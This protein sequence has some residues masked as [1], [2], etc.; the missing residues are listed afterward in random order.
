MIVFITAHDEPTSENLQVAGHLLRVATN[1][2]LGEDAV[3]ANIVAALTAEPNQPLLAFSHGHPESIRG[4]DDQ[5]AL[6]IADTHLLCDRESF[7]F[8]CHT[9]GLLGPNVSARGGTWFGYV[10]AVN[11][12]PADQDAI[13]HFSAIADFVA[14]RFPGCNTALGAQAF[15]NDIAALTDQK[16][17][18]ILATDTYTFEMLHALRDIS[19]RLRIWLP[20][21][22][23]AIM[24]PEGFGDP[25]F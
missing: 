5:P 9:A 15:I 18:A 1:G 17:E 24:H 14:R 23:A 3:R 6:M 11:C 22:A 7:A 2:L 4:N 20:G 16:H 21:A 13:H 19:R 8:A 12:L 10:G 25:I